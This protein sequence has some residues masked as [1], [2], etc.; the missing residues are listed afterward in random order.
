M[1]QKFKTLSFWF[2]LSGAIVIVLDTISNIVGVDLYSK[3]IESVILAVCSA[4]VMLGIITKKDS[5][6]NNDLSKNELLEEIDKNK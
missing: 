6:D 2:G 4:L 3:Q 1:R 5:K